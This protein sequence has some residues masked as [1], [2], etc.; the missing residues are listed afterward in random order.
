VN[1]TNE[2]AS[3]RGA[4]FLEEDALVLAQLAVAGFVLYEL[5][6]DFEDPV[7][8]AAFVQSMRQA[9]AR[10]SRDRVLSALNELHPEG[11]ERRVLDALLAKIRST[12]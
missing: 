7:V 5:L 9:R 11:S 10:V 12:P 3:V 1:I 6:D 4:H 8:R 2:P